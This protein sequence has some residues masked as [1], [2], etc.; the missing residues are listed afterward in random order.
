MVLLRTWSKRETGSNIREWKY[1]Y[2]SAYGHACQQLAGQHAH[3]ADLHRDR[4][5]K[6]LQTDHLQQEQHGTVLATFAER[7]A[8][9]QLGVGSWLDT[10][11]YHV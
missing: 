1:Y 4:T 6:D 7:G 8:E 3:F 11:Q 2:H 9:K 10:A 5:D